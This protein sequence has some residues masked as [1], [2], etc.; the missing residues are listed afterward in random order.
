MR[1][2]QYYTSS[3]VAYTAQHLDIAAQ[4]P[5][6]YWLDSVGAVPRVGCAIVVYSNSHGEV[7]SL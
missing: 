5:S 6:R 4:I 2:L 3:H 7:I 1:K